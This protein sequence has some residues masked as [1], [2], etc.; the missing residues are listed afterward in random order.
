MR[1]FE[2]RE[3]QLCLMFLVFRLSEIQRQGH[4]L[5][6]QLDI[7]NHDT[8]TSVSS[9]ALEIYLRLIEVVLYLY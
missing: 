4:L 7:S 6:K 9:N 1:P 2:S 5:S 8:A 3:E